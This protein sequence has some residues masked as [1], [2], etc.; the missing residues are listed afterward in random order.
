MW[1]WVLLAVGWAAC[2][3]VAYGLTFHY[4]QATWPGLAHADIRGDHEIA[5]VFAAMGPI[6]LVVSLVCGRPWRLQYRHSCLQSISLHWQVG[7]RYTP[8]CLS[9]SVPVEELRP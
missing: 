8:S 7:W 5:W 2:G 3:V 1:D 4:F 6:G 9:A